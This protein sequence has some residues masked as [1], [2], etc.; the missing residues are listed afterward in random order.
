L[1]RIVRK[2][3]CTTG[4]PV[5]VDVDVDENRIVRVYPID[6]SDDDPE[7][8]VIEAR[9]RSFAPPRRTTYT[10]YTAGYKAMVHSDR[11][12]LYPLKRIG[13]D[14]GGDR[15]EL[16]RGEPAA[17]GDPNY[18]GY[19]RIS[20]DEALDTVAGEMMRLKREFGPGAILAEPSSH[21]LWGDVGY[22]LSALYRFMN[23]AGIMYA[24][25]NPDSWEGWYWGGIHSWGFT[26][27]LGNP[28]Q[29]DLLEDALQNCEMMVFWSSD[30][31]TNGGVYGAYE[32]HIRRRWLK[33]LG[34]KMVFIDPYF[35]HTAALFSD[36]WIS[37]QVG[38]DA[39]LAAAIAY[40]WVSE[41]TYDKDFVRDK[42]FGFEE[43]KAYLLGESDGVPK[44]PEW[45]EAESKV[46][47]R[48]IRALA[49]EWAK[50]KTMLAAGGMAG[51]G[52]A[53]RGSTGMEWARMMIALIALQGI[54]KPGVNMYSTAQGAPTDYDFFYPGYAGGGISGDC[55][56]TAAGLEFVYRMFDGVNSSPAA[57]NLNNTGGAHIPRLKIPECIT[58]G[59]FGPWRGKGSG[60]ASVEYQFHE[61]VYPTP[62]YSS[63]KMYYKYG[64]PHIGTMGET[65]RYARMYRTK[66]LPMV[67]SQAIWFEGET[68]FADIILPACTNFERW[69][70]GEFANCGGYVAGSFTQTNHRVITLI[71]KCIE[72]LGESKADYEIFRLL[73]QRLGIE[74][75]YSEG[76]DDLGWVKQYFYATDLPKIISWEDFFEKGY[77]VVPVNKGRKKV[78]AMRWFYEGREMDSPKAGRIRPSDQVQLKGLQT[79]S[80]KIELVANSLM[81]FDPDDKERPPLTQY[82]PSW[83]GHHSEGFKKYPLAVLSP[84]PRFSFHTM[85]D[86]KDA[87]MNDIKDHRAEKDGHYYWIVRI[88]TQD[89]AERGVGEGDLVMAYN[90]RGEVV[91]SA[92]VTERVPPGTVHS[93]MASAEYKPIGKPGESP[94]IGGCINI[95]SP[96][97]Y[98]GK[99]ACGM[100]TEHFLVELE[101]WEGGQ[102]AARRMGAPGNARL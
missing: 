10:A 19:E 79:Q 8:W 63:I 72:P 69:D 5:F 29:W 38:T 50:R 73:A 66:N 52:G 54:G 31:E 64:G 78:P 95:L 76:K 91:L 24:D 18:P 28:E 92:Q 2:T 93:Y 86:G 39:A 94:D 49:R 34:V 40:V 14:A 21:H 80:G 57:S 77:A 43:F 89:A 90:D 35:N 3:S 20:W 7:S 60:P 23:L 32:S 81:R 74:G 1:G 6:L 9:G 85:G 41:G 99:N 75:P 42:V 55:D 12:I 83:E 58:D 88:N 68:P 47:A 65:N 26:G 87:F 100:A 53:C 46:P 98:M 25:H 16:K 36:K 102:S 96:G 70:I 59:K 84:H 33:E 44:T 48:E 30:P 71:K 62:G 17:G 4:G 45:A 11:R 15:G 27:L 97:R 61:Y 56:N 37:P 51:F 101:K 67:V 13:F 82:I 22:R